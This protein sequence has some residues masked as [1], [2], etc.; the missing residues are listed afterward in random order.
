MT[1]AIGWPNRGAETTGD[2]ADLLGARVA[3]AVVGFQIGAPFRIGRGQVGI[4][5]MAAQDADHAAAD[6]P[7]PFALHLPVDQMGGLPRGVPMPEEIQIEQPPW[8]RKTGRDDLS[9]AVRAAQG[10]RCSDAEEVGHRSV[11][12]VRFEKPGRDQ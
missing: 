8:M 12:L 2:G 6:L 11:R 3:C 4:R 5:V 1:V 7:R 10:Q 9:R